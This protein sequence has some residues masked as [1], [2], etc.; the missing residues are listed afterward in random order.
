MQLSQR[1][2]IYSRSR[3]R[4]RLRG[5]GQ[6]EKGSMSAL[7]RWGVCMRGECVSA[8]PESVVPFRPSQWKKK[9][10]GAAI[11]RDSGRPEVLDAPHPAIPSIKLHWSC[12][13]LLQAACK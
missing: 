5:N 12:H 13:T 1:F 8:E 3:P 4:G 10:G 6:E 11:N 9:K 7:Y 2:Q